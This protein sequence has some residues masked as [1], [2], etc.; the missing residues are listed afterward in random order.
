M[1]VQ[2]AL[3]SR[4]HLPLATVLQ[5]C[6][7]ASWPV[8]PLKEVPVLLLHLKS[9]KASLAC[10]A[11]CRLQVRRVSMRP[12][13]LLTIRSPTAHSHKDLSMATVLSRLNR[14]LHRVQVSRTLEVLV[15]VLMVL[16]RLS[17]AN[18]IRILAHP[19]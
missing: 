6:S 8:V 1:V 10:R 5:T 18:L 17:R 2:L 11:T 3:R 15:A 4:S 7:K 16:P 12:L 9:S 14:R 13:A 19:V